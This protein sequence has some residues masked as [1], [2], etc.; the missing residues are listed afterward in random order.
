MESEPTRL[1]CE[2]HSLCARPIV[3]VECWLA[4]RRARR[5]ATRGRVGHSFGGVASAQACQ[6]DPRF[7][8][9]LNEDGLGAW[10]PFNVNSGAWR[11]KQ[12]FMLIFRD[13]LP[14]PPPAE[15]AE[16]LKVLLKLLKRDHE[17]A[18]KTVSGGAYEVALRAAGTSHADF[19]DCGCWVR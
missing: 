18:M 16:Q 4:V 6:T 9:C 3:A 8:A 15:F 10:R 12:R 1:A 2:G 11:A 14:G 17:I 5:Y 7:S 19:S 13:V